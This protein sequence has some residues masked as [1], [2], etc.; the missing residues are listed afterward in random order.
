MSHNSAVK[1][2]LPALIP[3]LLFAACGGAPELPEQAD[4]W[5]ASY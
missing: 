1:A 5:T 2:L 4:E 3:M